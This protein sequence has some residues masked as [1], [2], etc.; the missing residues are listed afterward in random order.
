MLPGQK[1]KL[2]EIIN[3]R[4]ENVRYL[5]GVGL[6]ENVVAEPDLLR[7]AHH[8]DVIIFCLPHQFIAKVRRRRYFVVEQVKW[9][10]CT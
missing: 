2:S 10:L 9:V 8:A 3:E 1:R 6:P 5:P 4:H 7:A